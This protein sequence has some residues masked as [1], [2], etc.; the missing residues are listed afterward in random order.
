MN[1]QWFSN[2][3]CQPSQYLLT[4]EDLKVLL[5][6]NIN[7][8]IQYIIYFRWLKGF[9]WIH[10]LFISLYLIIFFSFSYFF[11]LFLLPSFR[12][13]TVWVRTGR[14][15]TLSRWFWWAPFSLWIWSLAPFAGKPGMLLAVMVVVLDRVVWFLCWVSF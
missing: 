4:N 3:Y 11:V 2:C 1:F 10:F 14:G 5:F 7:I 12:W 8:N 9:I 13:T 15:C 6:G